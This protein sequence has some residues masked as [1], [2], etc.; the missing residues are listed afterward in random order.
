M[1]AFL[2]AAIANFH[3]FG[4]LQQQKFIFLSIQGP[5]IQKL[6]LGGQN[7]D[8]NKT[9]F[10]LGILGENTFLSSSRFQ[11]PLH[12]LPCG[13]LILIST[14][15][16]TLP[17]LLL[18]EISLCPSVISTLVF[19]KYTDCI[20]LLPSIMQDNTPISRSFI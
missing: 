2:I 19:Y 5:G 16:V 8:V 4:S 10:L 14:S 9:M 12:S 13:C 1:P 18:S 11:W 15:L 7:S 3:K 6:V 20:Y 17:S